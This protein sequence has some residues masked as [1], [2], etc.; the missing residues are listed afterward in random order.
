MGAMGKDLLVEN[1]NVKWTLNRLVT[2]GKVE[3]V[4][5]GGVRLY[6]VKGRKLSHSER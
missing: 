4:V 5:Y 1:G 3:P 2:E 6:K